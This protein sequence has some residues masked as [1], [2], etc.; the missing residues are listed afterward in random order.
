MKVAIQNENFEL[1]AKIRDKIKIMANKNG[2][3]AS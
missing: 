3:S 2:K 1:A